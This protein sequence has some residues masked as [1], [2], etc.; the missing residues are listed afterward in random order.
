[1]TFRKSLLTSAILASTLGLAACGGSS[2]SDSDDSANAPTVSNTAPTAI[3]LSSAFVTEDTLGAVVGALS[4]TDDD[5]TDIVFTLSDDE[6][7]FEINESNELKLKDTLAINAEEVDSVEVT[8]TATDAGELSFSETLTVSVT[9]LEAQEGVNVY[10]FASTVDASNSAVSYTGQIARHALS[11]QIKSYIGMLSVDYIESE[12]LTGDAVKSQLLAYWNDYEAV[13]DNSFLFIDGSTTLQQSFAEISSSG[14]TLT[15]K[16]AGNDASKMSKDW[17]VEGT[18][19]GWSD[20]G[21]QAKTPEGLIFHYFDLLAEN[22]DAIA[23]GTQSEDVNA[24]DITAAYITTDGLDLNQLIQKHTLGAL[25]FSQGT[26]DYL[27]DGLEEDNT[28]AQSEGANYSSLEHQF[29][30]GFGYFGAARHYLEFSDDAIADGSA[31]SDIDSDGKI[32]LASEYSWGNSTN[33]AKRDLGAQVATDYSSAAMTAFI[34]GRKIINDAAPSAL[35]D[36][37]KTDLL[38]QRDTAVANWEYA[39]AATVVHYINDTMADIDSVVA[40]DADA[41]SFTDLAKHFSEMKGFALNFQFSPFSPFNSD[42][43]TGKFA[44]L[45]TLLGEAP[46]LTDEYKSQLVEAR[47]LMQQVYG[48]DAENVENW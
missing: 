44:E 13:K 35:T 26:D 32:D 19:E 16:I 34:A 39:I 29:D 23:N 28:D 8:I 11:A 46:V 42:E 4:A 18:F 45:H 15:G 10:E 36:E 17:L 41:E 21:T 6:Q 25:M 27:D 43:N 33:A 31:N 1:M 12:G 47:D 5:T 38:A 20:F 40:A 37:Q 22:V 9:D 24:N 7:Y 48:F 30:E 2:S 3:S 14:K